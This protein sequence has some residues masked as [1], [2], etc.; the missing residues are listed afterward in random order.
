MLK[1]SRRRFLFYGI[2]SVLTCSLTGCGTILYPERRGQPSGPLDWKIVGLDSIGLLFFFIPGVIAFAV[3]FINGTIYLPTYEYGEYGMTDQNNRDAKLRSVSIPPNR[4]S[5]A[6]IS[7]V[8]SKH[9]GRKVI[10]LPGEYETQPIKSI[11]EFWSVER[12]M[13]GQS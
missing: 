13:N 7:D 10:L 2:N 12:E 6:E 4:I 11:D 1:T 3:D 8:V 9:S 5:P